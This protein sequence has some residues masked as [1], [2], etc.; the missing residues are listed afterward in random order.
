MTP[1]MHHT[2]LALLLWRSRSCSSRIAPIAADARALR[3][4]LSLSLSLS[5][6]RLVVALLVRSKGAVANRS[7]VR[8]APGNSFFK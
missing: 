4:P 5:L 8:I 7:W 3:C 1:V 6:S 2:S